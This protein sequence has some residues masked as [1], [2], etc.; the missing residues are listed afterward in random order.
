M[1]LKNL[2]FNSQETNYFHHHLLL[3]RQMVTVGSGNLQIHSCA[4]MRTSVQTC[5]WYGDTLHFHLL[6]KYMLFVKHLI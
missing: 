4:Y 1:I 3:V 5:R 2:V 6:K